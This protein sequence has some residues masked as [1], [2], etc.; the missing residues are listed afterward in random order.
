MGVVPPLDPLDRLGDLVERVGLRVL[1]VFGATAIVV[2]GAIGLLIL[3]L[4]AVSYF[5]YP[6]R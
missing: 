1:Q 5:L 4:T 6:S 2:L 3:Y